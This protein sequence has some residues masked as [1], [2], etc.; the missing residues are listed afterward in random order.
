[1]GHFETFQIQARAG[2]DGDRS[3]QEAEA[4]LLDV[5]DS[6]FFTNRMLP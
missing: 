6:S 4:A 5:L 2:G 3:S 1:M